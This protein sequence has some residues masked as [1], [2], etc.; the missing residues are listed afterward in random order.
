MAARVGWN[1]Q[2]DGVTFPR[3][4]SHIV[5]GFVTSLETMHTQKENLI[6]L[7][8][9]GAILRA[10]E[11]RAQGV[12]AATITRAVKTGEVVRVARGLY[13]LSDSSPEAASTLA[14]A[15]KRVPKG[16]ICLMSALA[17]HG[18]TDQMPRKVWIA[19]GARDWQPKI[20]YP[21]LRVVRYRSP[22][23]EYGVERHLIS[24]VTVPIYT[25]PK[26]LADAFR[27]PRLVDRS[28][29]IESLRNA[30]VERKSSPAEIS[31][32]AIACNAWKRMRPYIETVTAHG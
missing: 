13:Q 22:Y 29:A 9:G 19:I 6:K 25:I 8:E 11:L 26:T 2:L 15:S 31:K 20:E 1:A 30:I 12:N 7:L 14:E 18:L 32:A 17:Y 4:E 23:L 5:L 21:P 27:N 10:N 3:T 24:G 16:V 28:V